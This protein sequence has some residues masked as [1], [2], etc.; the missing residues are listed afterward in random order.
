MFDIR[1][2]SR[3]D[4]HDFSLVDDGDAVRQ[5]QLLLRRFQLHPLYTE[6]E[7]A[8]RRLAEVP[9][10]RVVDGCVESGIIDALYLR[11]KIWTI[12]EFKTDRVENKA[13]FKELLEREDYLAQAQRYVAAVEQLLGQRP[14][15]FLCMLNYGG[16]A[17]LHPVE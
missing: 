6:M 15:S 16:A 2:A 7:G 5:S 8:D 12:V 11:G 9:Y 13:E 14:R 10:S 17:R 3:Q 4:T 1:I